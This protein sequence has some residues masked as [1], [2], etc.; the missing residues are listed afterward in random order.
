MGRSLTADGLACPASYP[1]LALA[2]CLLGVRPG[3]PYALPPPPR[4]VSGAVDGA[5]GGGQ[6][7]GPALPVNPDPQLIHV[8]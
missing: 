7:T 2:C 8:S 6:G 3:P 4:G 5:R 1:F